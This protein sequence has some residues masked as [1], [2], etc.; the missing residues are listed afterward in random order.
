[1][2]KELL[3]TILKNSSVCYTLNKVS[4]E[5]G[6]ISRIE[7]LETSNEFFNFLNIHDNSL[8]NIEFSKLSNEIMY[9]NSGWIQLIKDS[10]IQNKQIE[11]NQ[12]DYFS[13]KNIPVQFIPTRNDIIIIIIKNEILNSL[14]KN[15]FYNIS[16]EFYSIFSLNGEILHLNLTWER[17]L[18]SKIGEYQNKNF[19]DL[20][21][22]DDK[23]K[24]IEE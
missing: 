20:V 14:S 6:E 19:F 10:L 24:F 23:E 18:E 16:E 5:K 7:F 17:F 8:E 22:F 13:G 2:D 3:E 4:I 1:M 21:Y 12:I 11:L 15:L 9:Y